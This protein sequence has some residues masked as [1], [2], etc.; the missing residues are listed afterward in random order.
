MEREECAGWREGW[1][2]RRGQ[3]GGVARACVV[4]EAWRACTEPNGARH[5]AQVRYKGFFSCV[6][7][8]RAHLQEAKG[9]GSG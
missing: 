7:H 6:E 8:L 3:E 5:G 2:G 9:A 1:R 4:E